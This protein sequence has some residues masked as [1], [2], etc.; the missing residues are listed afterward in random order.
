VLPIWKVGVGGKAVAVG[1]EQAHA[2]RIAV[3]AHANSR[4]VL[5]RDLER[6]AG[7]GNFELHR[8]FPPADI[9]A[10]DIVSI[11]SIRRFMGIA[12]SAVNA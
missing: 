2:I 6:R 5:E 12:G 1:D 11:Q 7:R 4:P 10:P 9:V 8:G 3:P